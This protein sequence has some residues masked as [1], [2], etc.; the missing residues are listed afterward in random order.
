VVAKANGTGD[1]VRD[2]SDVRG[3]NEASGGDIGEAAEVDAGVAHGAVRRCGKDDRGRVATLTPEQSELVRK[4]LGLVA[5]HLRRHVANLAQPRHD[6]EWEDLFQEGC[7]GL[8]RA[9]VGFDASRG[10]A[11]AAFAF[12]RIHNAV[13]TA[14]EAKFSTIK[15]PSRRRG[16]NRGG[17]RDRHRPNGAD[18]H[19][20]DNSARSSDRHSGS[21][22]GHPER[23]VLRSYVAGIDRDVHDRRARDPSEVL[24]RGGNVV[25]A[26]VGDGLREKYERAVHRS[27]ELVSRRGGVRGDRSQLAKMIAEERLLVPNEDH[28]RALR[29]IARDT[30]SSYARVADC[31]RRMTDAMREMLSGDPEFDALSRKARTTPD[32]MGSDMDESTERELAR[33][34]ASAFSRRFQEANTKDRAVLLERLLCETRDGLSRAIEEQVE[35]MNTSQ[36]ERLLAT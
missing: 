29:Q 2:K 30:K 26:T 12:P 8:I 7:L 27:R 36:R 13:S 33:A 21:H 4:T 11:F 15:M 20:D 19:A 6:R 17:S 28:R 9:A 22:S 23:A 35:A 5:V 1:T 25:G 24:E 3:K 31:E 34:G 10:I 14:L 18:Q 32:G 16:G